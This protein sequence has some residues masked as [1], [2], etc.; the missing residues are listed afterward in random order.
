MIVMTLTEL[1]GQESGIVVRENT[2]IVTNWMHSCPEGG[3]PLLAPWGTALIAWPTE[4]RLDKKYGVKDIRE[5]LPGSVTL[6]DDGR[7]LDTDMDIVSDCNGDIAALWGYNLGLPCNAIINM[8]D[9]DN[10]I[11]TPG[12]VYELDDGTIVISPEGWC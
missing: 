11:P 6:G 8:D 2:V 12:T 10:L 7:T 9:N 3:L 4:I 1:T 5:A